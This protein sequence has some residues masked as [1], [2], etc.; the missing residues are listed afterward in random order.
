MAA[1]FAVE[2]PGTLAQFRTAVWHVRSAMSQHVGEGEG[3]QAMP[4]IAPPLVGPQPF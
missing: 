2:E 4:P 1:Q 3:E